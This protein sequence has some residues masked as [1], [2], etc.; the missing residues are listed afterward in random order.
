MR[1]E[2]WS[3]T[4]TAGGHLRGEVGMEIKVPRL[5]ACAR[6]APAVREW[7]DRF[8]EEGFSFMHPPE[9]DSP[10]VAAE[11]LGSDS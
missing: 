10:D 9:D 11:A 4:S 6:E 8:M 7:L 2:S 5:A 3:L 1:S